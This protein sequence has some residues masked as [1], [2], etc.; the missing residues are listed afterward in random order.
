MIK[1]I[2]LILMVCVFGVASTQAFAQQR[3][4]RDLYDMPDDGVRTIILKVQNELKL[5]P[6]AYGRDAE[7][8]VSISDGEVAIL[9]GVLSGYMKSCSMDWQSQNFSPYFKDAR[10]GMSEEQVAV[11]KYLHDFGMDMMRQPE[12]PDGAKDYLSQFLY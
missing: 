5:G 12:C 7:T 1:K 2:L 4:I 9:R 11:L 3:D 8:V 10:R 6:E